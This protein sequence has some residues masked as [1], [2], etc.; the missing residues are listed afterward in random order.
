MRWNKVSPLRLAIVTVVMA[1]YYG[2]LNSPTWTSWQAILSILGAVVGIFFLVVPLSSDW[3][4]KKWRAHKRSE[5]RRTV[6]VMDDVLKE[7]ENDGMP[8]GDILYIGDRLELHGIH[9][10]LPQRFNNQ[11]FKTSLRYIRQ[12]LEDRNFAAAIGAAKRANKGLEQAE[13]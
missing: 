6:A 8:V 11:H 1:A 13:H 2:F 12:H 10:E 5:V 7:L 9:L 4:R 3:V